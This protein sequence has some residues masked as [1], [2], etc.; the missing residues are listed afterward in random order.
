VSVLANQARR[1]G[2]AMVVHCAVRAVETQ[3]GRISGVLTEKG[4]IACSAVVLAGGAWSRLFCRSVGVRL[5]QL[6]VLASV[7]RVDGVENGPESAAWGPGF[8]FR[9]RLD[10][11]YT[12]ANGTPN[13][14]DIV[15]DS[16]RFLPAFLPLLRLEWKGIRLR[17]GRRF[18]EEA[19]YRCR[20]NG[21][22]PYEAHRILDP[23]PSTHLLDAGLRRLGDA[24]PV[25]RKAI[26][27]QRWAGLIDAT[28]DTLP[29]M[30]GVD[31]LPGFFVATGFS[32]H[33][34]GIGPAAG[35]LMAD[36]VTNAKPVVDPAP[37]R[38]SRF[39]DGSRPLPVTGL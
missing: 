7:M 23:A 26:V 17:L 24:F 39:T 30:S 4:P 1:L 20:S 13:I 36:L 9:K 25:F 5:P 16:F 32:G 14:A 27:R 18:V 21:R 22:T 29:I 2:A 31:R 33:G 15:P 3:A 10:G 38:L 35:R 37:F 8:A 11:G 34:F 12:V 28:P 6:K 19:G